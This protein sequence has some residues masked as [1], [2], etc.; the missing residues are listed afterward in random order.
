MFIKGLGIIK[1]YVFVELSRINEEIIP[2]CLKYIKK[3]KAGL[4]T[5]TS[6]KIND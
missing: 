3:K 4:I 2:H 1:W 6:I 5:I